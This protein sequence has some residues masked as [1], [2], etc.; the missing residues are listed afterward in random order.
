MVIEEGMFIDVEKCL[1]HMLHIE[2]DIQEN[3]KKII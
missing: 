2:E 1:I 3:I